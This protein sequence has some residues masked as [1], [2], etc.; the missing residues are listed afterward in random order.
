MKNLHSQ[1]RQTNLNLNSELKNLQDQNLSYWEEIHDLKSRCKQTSTT[2]AT[3]IMPSTTTSTTATTKGTTHYNTIT[4]AF[5]MPMI[6]P[7]SVTASTTTTTTT[8]TTATTTTT[9]T[10]EGCGLSDSKLLESMKECWKQTVRQKGS[11]RKFRIC[12]KVY[13]FICLSLLI[14]LFLKK[15][16]IQIKTKIQWLWTEKYADCWQICR[17]PY[18]DKQYWFVN[19]P[20]CFLKCF[21]EKRCNKTAS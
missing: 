15:P 4:N 17:F 19:G 14:E 10:V 7:R 1:L 8:T 21:K 20:Q 13:L 11:R 12:F 16:F 18:I 9:S 6:I 5:A 2:T 3:S